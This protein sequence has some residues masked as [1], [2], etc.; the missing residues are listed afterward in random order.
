MRTNTESVNYGM[1]KFENGEIILA[2]GLN[3]KERTLCLR[4]RLALLVRALW[5]AARPDFTFTI[6]ENVRVHVDLERKRAKI[7]FET[8]DAKLVQLEASHQT[9]NKIH[10]KIRKQMEIS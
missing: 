4:A 1:A 7:L 8:K 2:S 5:V 6:P 10:N 9:I 3:H